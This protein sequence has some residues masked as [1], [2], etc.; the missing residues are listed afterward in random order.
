MKPELEKLCTDYTVNRE[1][2]KKAFRWDN[3]AFYAVCA[4]I[5]CA[6]GHM[7]DADRLKECRAVIKKNTGAFSKFRSK[8]IRSIL[9][10]MLALGENPESRMAQAN[11]YYRLLR[12]QFK[13]T[14]YLVLTAFLLTDLA[15]RNVTEETVTRGRELYRRMNKKHRMLTDNTDSV[16]AMLLANS[17]KTDDELLEDMEAC[18]LV[19]KAR[20]S[21]GSGAQTAAQILSMAAGTA[22]EKTQRVI[23]LYDALQ[24][25]GVEYGHSAELAPLAALS[26]SDTPV[27]DLAEEIREADEFLAEQNLYGKKKEDLAQRA[28]HAVMIVSDQYAGTSQVNITVLT[29]TLDMLIAQQQAKRISLAIHAVEFAAKFLGKSDTKAGT[30]DK[31]ETDDANTETAGQAEK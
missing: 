11:D 4:N 19:L 30:D 25:A 17:D 13:G 5:F 20:F 18:Y 1:A 12:K 31:T 14:E 3:S 29:N 15:D 22:E 9:A 27:P 2:V 28:M 23:E 21:N 7:A 26:L 10:G 16:F 24:E 6:N 8:R